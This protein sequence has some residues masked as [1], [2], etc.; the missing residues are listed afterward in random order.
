MVDLRILGVGVLWVKYSGFCISSALNCSMSGM[1]HTAYI[2]SGP[3]SL[4]DIGVV[5]ST[6]DELC[7]CLSIQY[8]RDIKHMEAQ[9]WDSVGKDCQH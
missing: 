9:C 1:C 7:H 8:T 2:P 6:G 3:I 5:A 4:H